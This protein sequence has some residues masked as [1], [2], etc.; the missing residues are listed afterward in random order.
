MGK[1]KENALVKIQTLK[2]ENINCKKVVTYFVQISAP[3]GTTCL[4]KGAW[5]E[6]G[7]TYLYVKFSEQNFRMQVNFSS[8]PCH[9]P[10]E[11]NVLK[12]VDKHPAELSVFYSPFE[13][14]GEISVSELCLL[15]QTIVNF[16]CH[17]YHRKTV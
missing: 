4:S 6:T 8:F 7:L 1:I 17:I 5:T 16:T 3:E 11:G 9:V 12:P 14:E 2:A 10:L 13:T 15:A